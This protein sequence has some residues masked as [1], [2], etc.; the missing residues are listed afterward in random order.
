MCLPRSRS[1]LLKFSETHPGLDG[2]RGVEVIALLAGRSQ[3]RPDRNTYGIQ[4]EDDLR[5]TG[6]KIDQRG[7][8]GV[9]PA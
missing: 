1:I 7:D 5:A 8:A 6:A 3:R 9:E 2:V 4:L